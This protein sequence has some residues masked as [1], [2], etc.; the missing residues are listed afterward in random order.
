MK[1][2]PIRYNTNITMIDKFNIE[3]TIAHFFATLAF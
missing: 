1:Y 3:A 2:S